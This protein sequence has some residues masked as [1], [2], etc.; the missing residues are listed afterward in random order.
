MTSECR[1]PRF[2]TMIHA[3]ELGILAGIDLED[4]EK[5]LI[6]CESCA[7]QVEKMEEVG[8]LISSD[9]EAIA[10]IEQV[11]ADESP[12]PLAEHPQEAEPRLQKRRWF[13]FVSVSIAAGALLL[14]LIMKPWEI[15]FRTN[16]SAFADS[17]LTIMYF[18]N[19]TDT[20]DSLRLGEIAANLLITDLSES[21]YLQVL[22]NQRLYDILKLL[23]YNGIGRVDR[24]IADK[25]AQ[26]AQAKWILQGSILQTQPNLVLTAQITDV[27]S[28]NTI[29]SQR[30]VGQPGESII[31]VV[32]RLALE[33]KKDLPLP[34]EAAKESDRFLSEITTKS[35][36]AYRLYLQGIDYF[37]QAYASEAR[38]SFETALKYDSTF[39][40]AYYYL[41][42]LKD[43]RLINK[44]KEYAAR[45]SER[46]KYYIDLYMANMA[47]DKAAS[48]KI[49]DEL[50]KRY[51]EDKFAYSTFARIEHSRGHYLRAIELYNKAIQMDSLYKT[52]YVYLTYLYEIVDST[53]LALSTADRYIQIAANE[54]NPYDTKADILAAQ[55]RSEEAIQSYRKALAVK[56]NFN[57]SLEK[58]GILSLCDNEPNRADSCFKIVCAT[59]DRARLGIG[60]YRRLYQGKFNESLQLIDSMIAIPGI[61]V[62]YYHRWKAVINAELGQWDIALKE[63]RTAFDL[64]L[65]LFP[66]DSLQYQFE[67]VQFLADKGD[68]AS[69]QSTVEELKVWLQVHGYSE[70]YYWRMAG[71]IALAKGDYSGAISSLERARKEDGDFAVL[72]L[73][74][75]AYLAAGRSDSAIS[76][77]SALSQQC[78]LLN[79]DQLPAMNTEY[80]L[81][82]AFDASSKYSMAIL[83]YQRFVDRW[84]DA[85]PTTVLLEDARQRLAALKKNL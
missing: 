72:Y 25:V 26:K 31:G 8:R 63:I 13:S 50:L 57:P 84:R 58:L 49:L 38:A 24:D 10:A 67:F 62:D 27:A 45:A 28:G 55:G 29:A 79:G 1:D 39:A 35:Q 36:E 75:R 16:V 7:A 6:E 60:A 15:T 42:Q 18:E 4:F 71:G 46:D 32:D 68:I 22:S 23:E 12:R 52:A 17:R 53:E 65:Q 14:F 44:A 19:V 66:K 78:P 77:F 51:P 2:Q 64:H 41:A 80:Y 83:H 47:E 54:A 20:A 3:Y 59:S 48:A 21:R 5:H 40:M 70:G 56:S 37:N 61:R 9:P 11:L 74:G 34:A 43:A 73:L 81:A 85:K 30:T 33:V 69:A 76:I 82:R